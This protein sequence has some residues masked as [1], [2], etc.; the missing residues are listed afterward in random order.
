MKLME[1]LKEAIRDEMI[2]FYLCLNPDCRN[3]VVS[4]NQTKQNE[5]CP[6]CQKGRLRKLRPEEISFV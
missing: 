6:Y 1:S 5:N 4:K 3:I 2:C